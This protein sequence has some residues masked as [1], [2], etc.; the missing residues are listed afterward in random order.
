LSATGSSDYEATVTLKQL[1]DAVGGFIE[2]VAIPNLNVFLL[3]DED[4]RKNLPIN[5]QASIIAKRTI[6]GD[7]ILV[8]LQEGI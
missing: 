5:E 2:R 7:A 8:T 3:V 6:L 4:I 1:Q